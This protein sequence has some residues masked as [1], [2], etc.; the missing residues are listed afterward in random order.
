M[1]LRDFF[2]EK[3]SE[4]TSSE[5][6]SFLT[7]VVDVSPP[8]ALH[9]GQ[10]PSRNKK[11][12]EIKQKYRMAKRPSPTA[13]R[14]GVSS[15]CFQKQHSWRGE[16][17]KSV[18][19]PSPRPAAPISTMSS[20]E[21]GG[22]L[23]GAA[24]RKGQ[25]TEVCKQG[26]GGAQNARDSTSPAVTASP[27]DAARIAQE[28]DLQLQFPTCSSHLQPAS[29]SPEQGTAGSA[30]ARTTPT[31]PPSLGRHF[32]VKRRPRPG[33]I[34]SKLTFVRLSNQHTLILHLGL[35]AFQMLHFA[36]L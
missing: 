2:S 36:A 13:L 28:S 27:W 20:P 30:W 17:Q 21:E 26:V 8:T 24:Q 25:L 23:Q 11:I 5:R 10:L 14:L 33:E 6:C 35:D 31:L 12:K 29:E 34:T 15:Q 18:F 16:K 4:T 22:F 19:P 7:S 32:S 3:C 9:A 1:R